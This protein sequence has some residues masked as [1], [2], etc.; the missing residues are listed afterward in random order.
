[1]TEADRTC[2]VDA[3][4]PP[5]A[6]QSHEADTLP[7]D[8]VG[9]QDVDDVLARSPEAVQPESGRSGN[10]G[11]RPGVER[12]GHQALLTCRLAGDREVDTGQKLLPL[13]VWPAPKV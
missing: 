2:P 9:H 3:R 12:R 13:P 4:R 7:L 10:H 6:V 1:M 5:G 11:A 8:R